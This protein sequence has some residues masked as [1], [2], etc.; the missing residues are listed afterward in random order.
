MLHNLEQ[1]FIHIFLLINKILK[2]NYDFNNFKF[3]QKAN[4]VKYKDFLTKKSNAVRIALF[5]VI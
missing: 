3:T 4:I 2:I 5:V 1:L